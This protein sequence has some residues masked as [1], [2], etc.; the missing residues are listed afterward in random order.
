MALSSKAMASMSSLSAWLNSLASLFRSFRDTAISFL[1]ALIASSSAAIS[2]R[3]SSALSFI[4]WIEFEALPIAWLRSSMSFVFLFWLP[5]QRSRCA[6]SSCSSLRRTSIIL[7][8]ATI[9]ESKCPPASTRRA[10]FKSFVARAAPCSLV[11]VSRSLEPAAALRRAAREFLPEDPAPT[12]SSCNS[13]VVAFSKILLATGLASTSMACAMPWS[14][15][16]R[17]RDR[18]AHC[19]ALPLQAVVASAKNASSALS[20][21]C[22]S[23]RRCLLSARSF[24]FVALSPLCKAN[25]A[26]NVACSV[27]FVAMSPSNAFC[28]SASSALAFSKELVKASYKP[29]RMPW[30]RVDCGA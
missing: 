5:W 18:S 8:M 29:L 7:S 12:A 1:V 30:I 25:V 13:V 28:S 21:A 24:A 22:V 15:S 10:M 2:P 19:V 27:F 3:R 9:T 6:T 26:F 4:R 20:C 14:S 23:S 16:V 17:R 11:A